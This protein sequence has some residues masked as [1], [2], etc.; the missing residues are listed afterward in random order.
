MSLFLYLR[1]PQS[2]EFLVQNSIDDIDFVLD[3]DGLRT[4]NDW[5]IY[6]INTMLDVNLDLIKLQDFDAAQNNV[7]LV[8]KLTKL[9]KTMNY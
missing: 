8:D 1:N 5:L 2:F 3:Y 9:L 7:N 4:I 6:V